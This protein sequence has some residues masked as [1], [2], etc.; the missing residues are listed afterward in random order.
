MILWTMQTVEVYQQIMETGSYVCDKTKS[1]YLETQAFVDAY[2][3]LVKQMDDKG[4]Y[5][6]ENTEYPVWAWHTHYWKRKQPDLRRNEYGSY[7]GR[8][9][10]CLELD[11]PDELV[12]LSDFDAWH[13][14]LNKCYIDDSTCEEEYDMIYDEFDKL[15]SD[16][17]D[18]LMVESWNKIFDVTTT[19]DTEWIKRGKFIQATFWELK[20]EF[21][22]KVKFF[23]CR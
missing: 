20:K 22:K 2:D 6:P 23:K 15:P 1:S 12:L 10:V 9:L 8:E 21:V 11:I 17:R 4:I 16:E 5:H 19:I 14:V 18:R 7:R 3:W 13:D